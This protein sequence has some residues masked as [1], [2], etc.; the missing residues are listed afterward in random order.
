MEEKINIFTDLTNKY[1][2]II[3]NFIDYS[4]SKKILP[5][6]MVLGVSLFKNYINTEK[7]KIL[8]YSIEYILPNKHFILNF[9]PND[10]DNL[11]SDLLSDD[12][13]DN[14]DNSDNVSKKNCIDYIS[15]I[16]KIIKSND[17]LENGEI[18]NYIIEIKNKMKYLNDLEQNI[19]KE[20]LK[21]LINTLEN[22]TVIFQ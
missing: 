10:Y 22:I 15:K 8:K 1:I 2:S 20:F 3:D 21:I 17:E 16:K 4:V 7:I 5:F 12:N 9:T 13:S 14:S 11:D 6:K 18:F 19:I